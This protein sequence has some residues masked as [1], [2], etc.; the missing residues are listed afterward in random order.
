MFFRDGRKGHLLVL[1][2]SLPDPHE[3]PLCTDAVARKP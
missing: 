2:K 1:G 3:V